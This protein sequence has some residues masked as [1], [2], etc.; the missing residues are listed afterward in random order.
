M[1]RPSMKEQRRGAW[2]EKHVT[3][4]TRSSPYRV[5]STLPMEAHPLCFRRRH[6]TLRVGGRLYL[7]L[8]T[9]IL[10]WGCASA[11][12]LSEA[13][14]AEERPAGSLRVRLVFGREADLDLY[15]TDPK[16]E[17]VYFGNSPSLAGGRLAK[18]QR[19]EDPAPR[20]ESVTFAE[21]Q[22]GR[23]RVG[24]EFAKRCTRAR[25]AVPFFYEVETDDWQK[26]GQGE[27]EPNHFLPVVLE[28]DLAGEA[29]A[30]T[31]KRSES[32]RSPGVP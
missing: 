15:V 25:A 2:L 30:E 21:P 29:R 28:F 20:V 16:L 23:Y 7:L 19:C 32:P 9:S 31:L 13:L 12:P 5:R 26:K 14:D 10:A 11:K 1:R 27:I 17:T 22:P 3:S 8:V 6:S 24:V 18:D 4:R